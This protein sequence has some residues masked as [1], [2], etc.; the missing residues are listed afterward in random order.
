MRRP[1]WTVLVAAVALSGACGG[2]DGGPSGETVP[3]SLDPVVTDIGD[4][5]PFCEAAMARVAAYMGQFEGQVPPD[6]RYGGTAVAAARGP[7]SGGMN[8]HVSQQ[9]ETTEHQ[10]FINLMTLLQY[11]AEL[12][13]V[14]YLAESWDISNDN[15]TLT[16]HIRDD[17][18]W[19]DGELTDAYDVA[20]TYQRS[21][22]PETGFPNAAWFTYYEQGPGSVEVVDSFTVTF[23]MRPHAEFMDAWR[24]LTIMPQHLLEDVPSAELAQHPFGTVCPVGNGPFIFTQH[25][26]GASWTFQANPAFPEGLGGRPFLD[27]YIF[28]TIVDPTTVLTELLTESVDF[29]SVPTPDQ[30]QAILDSEV[31]DVRAFSSLLVNFVA[32][33]ARRPK[34][35][36]K[37]V[38]QA[39]TKATNRQE[40]VES[41]YQGY[42]RVANGSL[43]PH[44]WAYDASV[45]EVAMAYDQEAA[46]ALLD[47]AGWI[48][49]DGDG[50]RE[51]ADGVRLS[52]ELKFN[53]DPARQAVAEIMQ[54]QLAEVGIEARPVSV[55]LTALI[56]QIT[57]SSLRDFDGWVIAFGMDFA[58]NDA[59]MFHSA[60]A[61]T[62][63]GF[64]GTQRSDMDAYLDRIPLIVDREDA[65]AAWREY[66]E[67]LVDEQPF[68]FTY[69]ADRL[70]GVNK[71]LQNVVTDI[72][73]EWQSTKDW[74]IPADQRRGRGR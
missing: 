63:W 59:A 14:T 1:R 5:I 11:D 39:I 71:R 35:A 18:Y 10:N 62:D 44:H 70:D 29:Y 2:G 55:E 46:K 6:D 52:L 74:W 20:Y 12:N 61:N 37:R 21:V 4:G 43:P 32:W 51:N 28:R 67:L 42:A 41:I 49:R 23:R 45:G 56:G 33:N 17:V 9:Q 68:T 16:F 24:Q 57:D 13:P 30:L 64:A 38:R 7:L 25:R 58:Q 26:Q 48:D 8:G 27:R 15:T 40:M 66:Q 72:R 34:L 3:W 53:P 31:L 54:A 50:V 36:D 19:H 22:D 69:Y 73:G 47:D 60:S 65:K